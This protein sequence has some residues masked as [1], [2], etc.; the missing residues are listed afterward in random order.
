MTRAFDGAGQQRTLAAVDLGSNSFQMV[1]ARTAGEGLEVVDRLK[2]TVRLAAGL[3]AHRML[4]P[5]A[6][7]RALA[8][9]ERFGQRL[10]QLPMT[11]VRAVG[12]NSLRLTRSPGPFLD[13]AEQALGHPIE[14]IYGVEE[15]RLIYAG[16]VLDLGDTPPRRL[17]V[18][19]GGGSTEVVIGRL[20]T[21]T[22]LES[23]PLGAVL[24][25]QRF[26]PDGAIT[27]AAWRAA[28]MAARLQLT[29]IERSYRAAGWDV[30]L[31][32]SGSI[33]AIQRVCVAAGWA[34]NAITP[35]A[36]RK[37]GKALVQAGQV[38][39]FESN[40][41]SAARRPIFPGAVAVLTAL[42]ESLDV[43]AMQVADKA[44]REGVLEELLGRAD[45]R[46]VRAT[47]VAT[48]QQR[49]AVDAGHA[50]RVAATA[51]RL[52]EQAGGW[53]QGDSSATSRSLHWACQLHE[54]GLAIAH[55]GYHKHGEYIVR[56]ADLYGFSQSEQ[57]VLA[58][59]LRL[60]RGR[61]RREVL[62]ALPAK[63]Q[64]SV[65][66]LAVILRLAVLLNRGRDPRQQPPVHLSADGTRLGL[67]FDDG[68]LDE[69]PLTRADL[70]REQ[71]Y[72]GEAG[73]RL[74][75]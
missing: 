67:S 28:V 35:G 75:I 26:F 11:R 25:S 38:D 13:A 73:Y 43:Q 69:H 57:L 1:V 74:E 12:T 72:L 24:Q 27:K 19:I 61:F 34:E 52:L 17:V 70:A 62:A 31:G 37:L 22:L 51:E 46:G 7:A 47:S 53:L 29:P 45:Q 16:A 64:Q 44:L 41:L 49:Y 55:K 10:R 39:A 58:A 54:I 9:L 18:D 14:V 20:G 59:L 48:T 40:E 3:D 5:E 4:T 36:L 66:R 71:D 65:E 33:K 68:W 32:S 15:A 6:C 21:P 60:Q 50:T 2:E 8:C 30:A 42:F 23:L 63:Q 56:N